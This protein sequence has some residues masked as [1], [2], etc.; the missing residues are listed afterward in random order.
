MTLMSDDL[1][2]RI[3][4]ETAARHGLSWDG[5]LPTGASG[6]RLGALLD[7]QRDRPPRHLQDPAPTPLGPYRF[8][9]AESLLETAADSVIRLT[10][11]ERD[12][13]LLLLDAAPRTVSRQE[14]LDTIWG[15]AGGVE[16]HTLET[17]IYRLRQ[18]I[19]PHPAKPVLLVTEEDGYRIHLE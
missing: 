4:R 7:R 10:E 6:L 14:I 17:H 15:Y 12:L 5:A 9:P 3:I 11:K 13:L 8:F 1:L 16:T 19:E 18:K 2:N